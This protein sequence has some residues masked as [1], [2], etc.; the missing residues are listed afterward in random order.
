MSEIRIGTE[1]QFVRVTV[2]GKTYPN[3][4]DRWDGGWLN[5]NIDDYVPAVVEGS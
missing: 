4:S 3:S 1:K 5:S 2:A